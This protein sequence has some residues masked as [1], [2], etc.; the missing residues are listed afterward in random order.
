MNIFFGANFSANIFFT[1]IDFWTVRHPEKIKL[2][3]KNISKLR[4]QKGW[5]QQKLADES[6]LERRVL[7]RIEY[8]EGGP[9]V[10]TRL[11]ICIALEANINEVFAKVI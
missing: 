11:S 4:K 6:D 1:F 10:D 5:S 9:T 8:G 2:L 7:Q 3:G